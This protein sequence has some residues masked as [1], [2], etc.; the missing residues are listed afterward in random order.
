MGVTPMEGGGK[1][2]GPDREVLKVRKF[3]A[4]YEIRTE[5]LKMKAN[6]P[7]IMR[8]AYTPAGD[9]IGNP[10]D[11]RRLVVERGIAPE[12][13]EPSHSVCS[14]GYSKK[15]RKWYGWSHRAIFGFTVGSVVKKGSCVA[16]SGWTEDYLKEHPEADRSLPVGFKAKTLADAKR[17]AVAFAESV[18]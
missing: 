14:I 18:S 13:A 2:G 16:E 6:P 3:R 4:G 8:S 1:M 7:V 11:A 15:E 5:K 12:K 17:M 9:Y 10:R